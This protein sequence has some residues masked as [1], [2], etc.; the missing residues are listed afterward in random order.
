MEQQY[1]G[2]NFKKHS[3]SQS[4]LKTEINKL[5]KNLKSYQ[6]ERF[7]YWEEIV[8]E[9]IANVAIPIKNKKGILLVKVPD[10]VW[11]F[12]LTR[13]KDEIITLINEH[14]KKNSIK[15]IVFL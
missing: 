4:S 1:S 10:S 9:K 6:K 11:R 8:G 15:D 14:L 12:E 5:V 2:I 7:A 3:Q 13:R